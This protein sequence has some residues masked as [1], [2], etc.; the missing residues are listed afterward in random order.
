MLI[1]VILFVLFY[2]FIISFEFSY[3]QYYLFDFVLIAVYCSP[4]LSFAFITLIDIESLMCALIITL[5]CYSFLSYC[6]SFELSLEIFSIQHLHPTL[7]IF[8]I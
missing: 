2:L 5:I 7:Y 1:A 6:Y 4:A 8:L 3:H